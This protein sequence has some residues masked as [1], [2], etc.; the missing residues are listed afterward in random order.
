MWSWPTLVKAATSKSQAPTRS[1][2]S[3]CEAVS[4]PAHLTPASAMR[5]RHS[6]PCGASVVVCP[7]VLSVSAPPTG[8]TT[9]LIAPARNEWP[10][11]LIPFTA[12][13]RSRGFTWRESY[14]LPPTSTSPLPSS[15]APGTPRARSSSLISG[16]QHNRGVIAEIGGHRF[17]WGSRTYVMGIVNVT[18]DSFSGDGLG[19]D[20]E[21]A[22][23]QG[24]RMVAE[25]AV[26][27]DVGGESTRPGHIPV[28]A[29]EEIARTEEVVQRLARESHVPVSIDSYK[30]EVAVAAVAAGATV[31]HDG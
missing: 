1:C 27:L 21:A 28:S 30:L 8:K 10:S 15:T 20:V 31:I 12:R 26:M 19:H 4:M 16:S 17:D 23:G 29:A 6:S 3:A 18:P 7:L 25:G 24:L 14:A 11:E 22:V 13:K 9:G 5:R 2:T